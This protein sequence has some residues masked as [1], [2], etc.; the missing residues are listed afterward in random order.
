M[1]GCKFCN[2]HKGLRGQTKLDRQLTISERKVLS[3]RAFY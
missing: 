2:E 3:D 1:K